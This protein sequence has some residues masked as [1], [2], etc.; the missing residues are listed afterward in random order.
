MYENSYIKNTI[1]IIYK[2][3]RLTLELD[4]VYNCTNFIKFLSG[5]FRHVLEFQRLHSN[6]ILL[7]GVHGL[8]LYHQIGLSSRI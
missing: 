4:N 2:Y 5:H 3:L 1:V 7:H 8:T 6:E